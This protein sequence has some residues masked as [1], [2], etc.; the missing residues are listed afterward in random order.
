MQNS[1][2]GLTAEQLYDR[3][4]TVCYPNPEGRVVWNPTFKAFAEHWGF[5]P[6]LCR[7]YRAQTKG[8]VESGVKYVKRNFLPGR[9]FVD[10]VD[11]TEQLAEWNATVAD[12]RVHGTTHEVPLRR[13]ERERAHLLPTHRQPSFLTD[14][15][16]SRIVA[17]DWLVSFRTNRYSVPFRLIGKPV[18]VEAREGLVR[19]YHAGRPVAE[20]RL[21]SGQH[22]LVIRPEHGPG[23]VA[24]NA[25]SRYANGPHAPAPDPLALD[26]EVRDLALYDTLAGGLVE[27]QP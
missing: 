4:R 27:V 2:K 11:F 25:R 24:R 22:E 7:A 19:I 21:C 15:R 23:A 26:V 1:E 18:E 5:E 17:R 14:A 8:K 16:V 3:P 10:I 20:H 6:R 13:F 12:T 9:S